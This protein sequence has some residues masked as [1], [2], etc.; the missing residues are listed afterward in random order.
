MRNA[1]ILVVLM[2]I[3]LSVCILSAKDVKAKVGGKMLSFPQPEDATPPT[4]LESGFLEYFESDE[5][6]GLASFMNPDDMERLDMGLKPRDAFYFALSYL[7]LESMKME[8]DDFVDLI[9]AMG[10]KVEEAFSTGFNSALA[11][12]SED[13][14][15]DMFMIGSNYSCDDYI[16]YTILMKFNVSGS[17]QLY[18]GN[19]TMANV[20]TKLIYCFTLQSYGDYRT[21]GDVETKS[22]LW[23]DK[24]VAA[25]SK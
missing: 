13:V 23:M 9:K 17:I 25:N 20:G 5:M 7:P 3:L 12:S 6:R 24:L 10:T 15:A 22:R 18:V 11:E 19:M 2:F 14:Q 4:S 8:G 21:I 1:K 16:S